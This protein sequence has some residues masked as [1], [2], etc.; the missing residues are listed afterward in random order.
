MAGCQ[1]VD[2]VIGTRLRVGST[3]VVVTQP[4]IPCFKLGIRM[5]NADFPNRFWA[6]GRLGFYVRVEQTGSVA[7]G[8]AIEVLDTPS[9]GITVHKLWR[10]VTTRRSDEAHH[11]LDKL[12]DLDAGWQRRLQQAARRGTTRSL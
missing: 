6:K 1:D 4:R 3:E 9:H 10:I 5:G 7:S 2:I 12:L 11:A 8:D